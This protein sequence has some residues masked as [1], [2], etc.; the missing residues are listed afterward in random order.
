MTKESLL[1][2][3]KGQGLF[4]VAHNQMK[5]KLLKGKVLKNLRSNENIGNRR[6]SIFYFT[7]LNKNKK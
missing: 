5:D 1:T 2:V 6:V 3:D 4:K 7:Y